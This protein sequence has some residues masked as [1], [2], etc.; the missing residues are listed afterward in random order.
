MHAP[1]FKMPRVSFKV[2]VMQQPPVTFPNL[3]VALGSGFERC[4]PCGHHENVPFL[5]PL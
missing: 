3:S 5:I 1:L 4:R 2:R